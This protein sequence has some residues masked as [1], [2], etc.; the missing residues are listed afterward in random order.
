MTRQATRRGE[1]A[2]TGTPYLWLVQVAVAVAILGLGWWG[3]QPG[4]Y[5]RPIS[6][7]ND[8]AYPHLPADQPERLKTLIRVPG[9]DAD[10]QYREQQF[11]IAIDPAGRPT[12]VKFH[13]SADPQL[14]PPPAVT[15]S[16][17]AQ[18]RSWRFVPFAL[19][20]RPV[21]ARFVADFTLV[22]EQDRP[23]TRIPFPQ[24]ADVNKV[25][26][27][28]DERGIRRL[29]RSLT[30]HG[31]GQVEMVI[32]SLRSDQHFQATIP[33]D[34]V[35]GLI[36][37]FRRA[38][39]FSLKDDYGGGPPDGTARTVSITID[40]QTKTVHDHEG[41]FGGLPDAVADIEDAIQRA[42]GFEQ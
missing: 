23:S 7:P 18:I 24:V 40:G 3:F 37:G 4:G 35:L 9:V 1:R 21:H 25:L 28:Y 11:E 42:G 36:D 2:K 41:Q 8:Q 15:D 10:R 39:F 30:V 34:K 29:P 14:V 20:G 16:A 32:S 31:D 26:M 22:P 6:F 17:I 12:R 19:E 13:P 27:T 5:L 33:R 38:D